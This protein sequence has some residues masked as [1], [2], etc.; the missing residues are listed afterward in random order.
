MRCGEREGTR[1]IGEE[2]DELVGELNGNSVRGRVIQIHS[3]G[4]WSLERR[5]NPPR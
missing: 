1:R 3:G 4:G 5:R 2:G